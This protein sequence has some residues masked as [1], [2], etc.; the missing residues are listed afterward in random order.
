MEKG[1]TKKSSGL[2]GWVERAGNKIPHPFILF[3]WLFIIVTVIAFICAKAGVSAV[4]PTTGEEVSAVNVLTS[5][6]IGTFLQTLSNKFLNF[7]PMMCVP[8]CVLGIGVAHGSGL[9]DVS[10]KLSGAAKSRF[11]L[12]FICA[13]IGVCAN[14]LGDAGY[15]ILPM[16]VAMLYQSTGRNPLAGVMLAYCSNCAGYG[17]N[18]LISTGDN[19]LAGL[20]EAAAKLIDPSYT[21]TPTCGW[22]FM[23]TSSFIVAAVCA[24]VSIKIVEPRMKRNGIGQDV[25]IV[26]V[27]LEDIKV[28]PEEKKGLKAVGITLLV[29]VAIMVLMCQKGMPWAAPEG[30]T[31]VTGL[32]LKSV[33]TIIFILFFVCG[34]VYGK[35]TGTIKKFGDTIPMM[36]KEFSTLSGYFVTMLAASMFNTVFSDSKLGTIIAIKGGEILNNANMAP[37]LIIVLFVIVCAI[38]NIFMGSATAK[39]ALIASTFVPMLMMAGISPEGTQVAY[40]IGDSLTNCI[41]PCFPYLAFII[42][43]CQRY[44]KRAGTGTV[45]AYALPYSGCVAL[46][47]IAFLLIWALIGIPI[48][49][50]A[51]FYMP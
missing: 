6:S 50:G 12:S 25:K 1:E 7:A 14:L 47:W 51:S 36:T 10:M 15:L 19:V 44:D 5:Q 37:A 31:V 40:R 18:L 34:Y 21:V 45:L 23:A 30:G 8:L 27:S 33:P 49:P 17:A 38:I 43:Y 26:D 39:Y 9:I 28:K 22:F 2:L 16:I 24:F 3:L 32:M 4:N 29:C 41:T 13:L 48:G 46:V 42:D 20:S 11:M 35:C